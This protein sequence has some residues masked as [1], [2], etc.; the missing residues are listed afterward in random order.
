MRR[1]QE[2]NEQKNKNRNEKKTDKCSMEYK[3]G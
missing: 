2:Q 3:D 1:T